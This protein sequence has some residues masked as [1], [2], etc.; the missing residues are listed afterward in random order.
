MPQKVNG[1]LAS[2]GQFFETEAECARHEYAQSITRL[3]E[4]HTIHVEN[5]FMLLREWNEEIKG[6]YHAD[7]ACKQS[8]VFKTGQVKFADAEEVLPARDDHKD[9]RE[10]SKDAPGFL[11]LA[12]RRDQ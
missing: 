9:A 3:C 10:R 5:F 1:Y 2:D 12:F 8:A 6:Y 4:A 11:E 7:E